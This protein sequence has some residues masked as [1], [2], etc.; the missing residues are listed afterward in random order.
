MQKLIFLFKKPEIII[1]IGRGSK[2]TTEAI[3]QTLKQFK[4]VS[5]KVSFNN[6]VVIFDAGVKNLE[7]FKFFIKKS[8]KAVLI[9]THIGDIPPD[10]NFFN[11]EKIKGLEEIVNSLKSKDSLILNSDD[12]TVRE[13]KNKTKADLFTFG[14]QEMARF[15]ATDYITTQFPSTGI[16]F[17]INFNG[18]VIPV[19]SRGIFGKEQVYSVLACSV[20]GHVFKL[21]LFEISRTLKFYHSLPGKM[22][23]IKG[24]KNSWILDDSESSTIFSM[25]RALDD[26]GRISGFNR[27][28]AVLGDV[29]GVGEY[30]IEEHE[31]I[32]EKVVGNIDILFTFGS[33]AKFIAKGAIEKGMPVEKIF[34]FDT[35]NQGKIK[36]QELIEENDLILID[37]S[38][39]M[40]MKDVVEEIKEQWPYRLEAQDAG[41]SSQ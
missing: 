32:G 40:K 6:E 34:E 9:I 8:R 20:C 41:F 19:W 2:T 37:G 29:I 30:T 5:K 26:I 18:S 22:Q 39:E 14:F 27:K 1:V 38:K 35:I 31:K 10:V 28:I 36:L 7:K 17:K 15:R 3:F 4:K 11:G 24:V 25:I 21:N 33:R 13:L 23:L 16:N 12:E